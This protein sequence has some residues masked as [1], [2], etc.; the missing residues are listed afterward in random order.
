MSNQTRMKLILPVLL[1]GS[2]VFAQDEHGDPYEP[3]GSLTVSPVVVQPGVHPN[4]EWGIE[5][6]ED[7]DDLVDV[8]DNDE[9]TAKK[10][11][12]MKVRVAGVAFQSGNTQLNVAHWVRIGG[13][14]ANWE[15]VFYGKSYHVNPADI[16]CAHCLI[17]RRHR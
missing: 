11:L 3:V 2:G 5:Y 14:S 4:M 13:S 16:G 7:I 8:G 17:D 6:P 12:T 15:L 10:D 1:A 9:L